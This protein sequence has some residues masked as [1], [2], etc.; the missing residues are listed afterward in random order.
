MVVDKILQKKYDRMRCVHHLPSSAYICSRSH[1][2]HRASF[3]I[4]LAQHAPRMPSA[5]REAAMK[6]LEGRTGETDSE[7]EH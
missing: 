6:E 5:V 2:L 1:G 3:G 7:A 4:V